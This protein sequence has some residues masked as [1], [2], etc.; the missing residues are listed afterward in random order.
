MNYTIILT[1]LLGLNTLLGG[2][3]GK[4]VDENDP[5]ALF[6]EAEEDVKNDHYQIAID[7]FRSIKNKFPYS[8]YSIDS[9]LRVADVYFLQDSFSEAALSY[10]SFK[11]LHPKHEK[12]AYA[13]FRIGKSYYN[14][15]PSTVARD[16]TPA[17]RALDA[18][19]DF[20]RRFP[21]STDVTEAQKMVS[22]IRN[23]LAEK[24][25]YIAHFY[26]RKSEY[27]AARRRYLKVLTLFSDTAFANEAKEKIREISE[28]VP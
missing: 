19:N 3:S 14:D 2:C 21:N 28:R 1:T 6:Q 25:I 17:R 9:Q 20:L 16:L 12:V 23:T 7:K 4:P 11:D 13:L 10:E 15:I 27:E 22:S 24:E 26:Y 5:A 8:K 18:L